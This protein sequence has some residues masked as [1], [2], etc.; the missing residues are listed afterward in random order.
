L[1][2]TYITH[3]CLLIESDGKK[4]L[5]DPWLVGPCWGNNIWHYPPP[6]KKPEDFENIDCLFISHAHDDHLHPESLSRMSDQTKSVPCLIPDF[7]A[8]YLE[9]ELHNNGVSNLV[10]MNEADEFNFTKTV[11]LKVLKNDLGDHD[12]SLLIQTGQTNIM[13]QTDNIMSLEEAARIGDKYKIDIVF[14]LTLLTGL[15]PA[16]FDFEPEKMKRLAH[17]KTLKAYEYS[18]EVCKKLRAKHAI[19]YASD[20]C[21]FGHLFFANNLHRGNKKDF[22]ELANQKFPELD[23]LIMGPNDS[24]ETDSSGNLINQSINEHDHAAE[25]LSS[26]FISIRNEYENTMREEKKYQ[27]NDLEN[28][29]RKFVLALSNHLTRWK[30]SSFKVVWKIIDLFGNEYVYSNDMVDETV[31]AQTK[32]L[33]IELAEIDLLVEL[34]SYRLQRL[35]KGDYPM[36]MLTLQNGSIRCYRNIEEYSVTEKYF[37]EWT[38]GVR[39]N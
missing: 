12:S 30:H 26:Y 36:G 27:D 24:F 31:E 16:F 11:K 5:T 33:G 18:I 8:R 7:G 9:N 28:D 14:N 25:N 1:K 2:F 38:Q 39:F 34:P 10:V 13:L 4:L 22:K 19:P 23:V 32:K 37:W 21:Y 20:L 17:Q 15:F 29:L 3:S 35:V 6:L